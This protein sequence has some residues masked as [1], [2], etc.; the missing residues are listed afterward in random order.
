MDLHGRA[1]RALG[2]VAVRDRSTEHGHHAVADMLVN[3]PAIARDDAVDRCEEGVQQ[4]MGLLGVESPS[5]LG[6]ARQIGE[7]H[8]HL[9]PFA[10]V[11]R[12]RAAADLARCWLCLG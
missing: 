3:A 1:D 11:L 8:G 12:G 4:L 7:Q 10:L 6:V 2:I 5:Q 9:A